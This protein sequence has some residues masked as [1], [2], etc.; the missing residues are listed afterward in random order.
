MY[1]RLKAY[2]GHPAAVSARG[3]DPVNTAMIRHWCEAVGDTHPAHAGED[4][5]AP[6]A[7]L[8]AWTLAGLGGGQAGRSAALG[9]LFALLDAAGFTAVVATD[10]EQEY[11]RP[12]RPGDVV[13]Y[14]SVIESVSPCKATKLGAGHFITTR[15]EVRTAGVSALA[16]T[17]RFRILR[18]AP[19]ARAA[20]RR[21][22]PVVG[23]DNAG[24]WAGVARRELLAQRCDDCRELRFPWLPG[25]GGCGSPRWTEAR[26]SGA[27]TV[28]SYVVVHHPPAPGF[29]PPYVVALVELAEGVRMLGNVTG[30]E[31]G[32]VHIGMRVR[33]EFQRPDGEQEL[34][35]FRPVGPAD[36]GRVR[37]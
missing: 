29:E 35:F 18:Y 3:K 25:C 14:D 2:E 28:Y 27:G 22:K 12:L 30:V 23:R 13:T 37:A 16:A 10:C 5:V 33:V 32:G 26:V 21:P 1:E 19:A 34:P 4:A 36:D 11:F 31:P 15:T 7:M 6:P 24:F 20:G 17:H 8:Q 9:E